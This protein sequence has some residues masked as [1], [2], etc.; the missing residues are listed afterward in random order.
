ME[1]A[2]SR[3]APR[4]RVASR[5]TT[6]RA[7]SAYTQPPRSRWRVRGVSCHAAGGLLTLSC[8]FTQ[9]GEQA[10]AL[11]GTL[12]ATQVCCFACA[13]PAERLPHVR[14]RCA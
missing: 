12:A 9:N 1:S 4:S 7:L 8:A 14:E 13:L 3:F 5:P 11:L 10:R 6:G 2:C